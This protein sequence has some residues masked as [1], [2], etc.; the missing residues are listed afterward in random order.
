MLY[1]KEGFPEESEVTLCTVS[2][3]H[4]NSV[5]VILD[6][7]GKTGII[8]I[9]EISP[10]RIRNIRDFVK[11]GKKVVCKILRVN[12]ERGHIDLS[13]RRVTESQRRAKN[14][15][16]KQEQMAEKIVE[17]VAKDT[18]TDMK[19]LYNDLMSK[20]KYPNLYSCFEEV[21]V[22]NFS[23]D[24]LGLDKTVTAKMTE[25]IKQ[26]IK[27]QEVVIGGTIHLLSY[28]SDGV[29]IVKEALKKA[30][31]KNVEIKYAGGGRYKIRVI[32]EDYKNA[33]DILER[34]T[35][36]AIEFIEEKDG[37]GSF[38]REEVAS[39]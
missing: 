36:A 22:D 26:R 13:L 8:S 23:L 4:Y 38:V 6:E 33:E 34:S 24:K 3:V 15:Q 29:E 27:P 35:K 25:M 7:Y 1:K 11:E 19:A 28:D 12:K 16:I 21:A 32:S 20:I 39:D 37:E 9:S 5:F 18:K 10:G 14:S 2:K 17:L 31:A 30:E